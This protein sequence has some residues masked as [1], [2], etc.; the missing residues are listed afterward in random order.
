MVGVSLNM[1]SQLGNMQ[2]PD[3]AK[4]LDD[5]QAHA[6]IAL[7]G[8]EGWHSFTY[9]G[10]SFEVCLRPGGNFHC[11]AYPETARWCVLPGTQTIAIA[12]G[13]YGN[14]ILNYVGPQQWAGSVAGNPDDWRKMDF[15]AA[16][17]Q[18]E[19][20]LIGSN[21]TGSQWLF[22]HPMG[23]FTVAF[24]ADGR[25]CFVCNDFPA[26]SHWAIGGADRNQLT[27][28]WKE[29]GT[30]ELIMDGSGKASGCCKGVPA[31]WRRMVHLSDFPPEP[32]SRGPSISNDCGHTGCF[33]DCQQTLPNN[34]TTVVT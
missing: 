30:Y 18:P 8:A 16:L 31:E 26:D 23:E 25:N 17:S 32:R 15:K 9:S 29:Y 11:P 28:D 14:Y 34:Q 27:I 5:V 3:A 24:L 4:F 22:K 2:Q 10:G 13:R 19:M 20:Q 1:I 21:G 33:G 6:P 12:W 7:T